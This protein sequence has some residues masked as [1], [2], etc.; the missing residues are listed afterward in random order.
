M[1]KSYFKIAWRNI[2]RNKAFSAIN[3]VGLALGIAACILILQYVA[4]ELSFDNFHANGDQIYRVR[5]DRYNE[6]KLSTEW[7]AGAFAVGNSFK[8]AYPEVEDYVKLINRGS[9]VLDHGERSFKVEKVYISS[10]SFF[11]VFSYPLINGNPKTALTE[12]N[13]VVLSASVAKKLFGSENPV[14]KII[15]INKRKSAKVTGVFEDMPANTHFK[16]DILISYATFLNDVKPENP[17]LAWQWDG[18]LT[19]LKLRAGTNI[20]KLEAKFP[21]LVDKLAGEDHKKYNSA[22]VYLLQPLKDIHLYSHLMMEAEPNGD[23]NTVYLL[24]GIAFFIV[25]IAWVN[26]INLSTA[27]AINR[28]REVGVRKAVGSQRSQLIGQ[29]MTESVLLNGL[30]V[31][32]ALILV[33]LSLPKFNEISGQQLSFAL[34]GSRM[35]WLPLITL[36]IV[37]AFFSGLY[38]AFVLSGFKPVVVLKGKVSTSTKGILLR[39]SLVVFQFAASLFLLVGTLTVF[40]QIRYM[41]QQS[42]GINI[43][44]TL[45]INPP[46]VADDSTFMRQMSAFKDELLRQSGVKSVTA[47]TVVPG[48]PS[49][50][51]AGGIRLKGTDESAG[52]QYRII[53]VDYDFLKTYDLKLVSGRNFSKEFGSD[54]KAVIF[55]KMAVKQLGFSNPDQAIGKEINFWGEIFT[56]V[57]VTDNF[58]QQSLKDAYEPLIIRLIPDIRGYFSVKLSTGQA[59]TSVAG[60]QSEWNR[61]FPGNPFEY[62]FLDDRFNDQY[63]A[64]QRFGQVFGVFTGLAILVACLGLFGLASFT[65]AQRT[66]E[67]GIRKVL[68]SSVYAIVEM[69]YRE[70]AIL[71]LISFVISAPLA[72]FATNR[73]L[74]GYAFRTDIQWWL[75]AAPFVLVLLIALLTVSFQSI[76]AALMNPV[77][78]LKSE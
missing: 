5:Q 8:E 46:I 24:L 35:F 37:G 60:I 42:L 52:K 53:G 9:M 36:F 54:P 4:F 21:A 26:Y 51:N 72:W 32:L 27:R 77:K 31:V 56:I 38:P 3:I 1:I 12:T 34:L 68:G 61:F 25:V 19:Y 7:A 39:K 47:S 22:A 57:G 55:N 67:I 6:G 20:P 71:I 63:K 40:Q 74:N 69:L 65:T 48:Q 29:F 41:R 15:Q 49:Q 76:K 62:S 14:G 70:F 16:T 66:K 50:W 43:D 33:A 2:V 30:A 64:D 28:A 13:T 11:S 17:D 44:Q 10:S 58:H 18:C 75:F 59:N 73:W 23:G 45:V 78:S